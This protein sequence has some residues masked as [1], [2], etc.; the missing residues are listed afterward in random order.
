MNECEP[1]PCGPNAVCKDTIG[2][3]ICSCKEDYTGDPL[4]GCVDIDECAVLEKPCGIHAICE[5]AVP[6]Y[7]C[8]C[9]QGYRG[10]PKPEV[11]CEQVSRNRQKLFLYDKFITNQFLG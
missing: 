3:Y 10:S 5:N 9:P 4:H 7:N 6:G 8:I 11:A 2:S 1:N